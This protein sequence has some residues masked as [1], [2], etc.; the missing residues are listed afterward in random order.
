MKGHRNSP[1]V[2]VEVPAI[3][4]EL[5]TECCGGILMRTSNM[6]WPEAQDDR[7]NLFM[8]MIPMLRAQGMA[9]DKIRELT[10]EY[11]NYSTKPPKV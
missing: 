6:T 5:L 1:D 4:L 2:L 7:Q 11:L 3:A 9:E 10:Q 8:R